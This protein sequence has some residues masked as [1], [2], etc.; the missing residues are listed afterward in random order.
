MRVTYQVIRSGQPRA[1]ADTEFVG[2]IVVEHQPWFPRGHEP[3][4][5]PFGVSEEVARR[6]AFA[7][8]VD[9]VAP[10]FRKDA[11]FLGSYLEY[12]VPISENTS[13]VPQTGRVSSSIW[14]WK[15]ITPFTD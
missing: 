4:W 1:Y 12:F 11:G 7:N 3:E 6:L 5:K 15:I 10:P 2:R 8:S 14:E 13:V 9:G